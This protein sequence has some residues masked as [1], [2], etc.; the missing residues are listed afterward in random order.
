MRAR[1]ALL[2]VF[3]LGSLPLASRAEVRRF[4]LVVAENQP[5]SADLP[6]LRYA[7][8]DGVRYRRLFAMLGADVELLAV[9]DAET[10]QRHPD[11]AALTRAPTLAN[12]DDALDHINARMLAAHSAGNVVEFFFVFAGHGQVGADGEGVLHFRDGLLRRGE[13]LSKVVGAS[14][15]DFNHL[16]LDACHASAMVFSRGAEHHPEDYREVIQRYLAAQDLDAYPNTGVVLAATPDQETH[17]WEAFR[18]GVF[19]HEVR[20]GLLGAADT[21]GDGYVEYSELWA[22]VTAANLSV[23]V[24]AARAQIVARPPLLDRNRPLVD[25]TAGPQHFLKLSKDFR[26]RAWLEDAEGDRYADFHPSGEAAMVIALADTGSYYLRRGNQEALLDLTRPGTF[27]EP[28]WRPRAVA[29]RGAVDDAFRRELFGV[30]FGPAFYQGFLAQSGQVAARTLRTSAPFPPTVGRLEASNTTESTRF[31]AWPWV[32]SGVALAAA[33]GAI[34]L[35]LSAQSDYEA[36]EKRLDTEGLDDPD[37]RDA[38]AWKRTASNGLS[39]GAAV[40]GSAALALFLLD[41]P[42]G[43]VQVTAG[44]EGLGVGGA[45]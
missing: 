9:L 29:R 25:F 35:G 36:V 40:A 1:M 3:L 16:I 20:S 42:V 26:G 23:S 21:N 44:P 28:A 17:E 13:F 41:G 33:G 43:P 27:E 12:L 39:I 18:A 15:A 5:M 37:R 4:A 24:T 38:V 7:D 34:A 30:P 2:L 14:R 19:S 45:F 10:Q 11:E 22:Y 8:D 32:A 31:G 6:P